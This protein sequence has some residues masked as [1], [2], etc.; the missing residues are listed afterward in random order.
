MHATPGFKAGNALATPDRK[1]AYNERV[2]TEIAPRYDRITR[3]LSFRRDA[4]WKKDLIARLPARASPRCLDV[5]CGTGDLAALLRNRYPEARITGVDLTESMLV[6]ARRRHAGARIEFVRG[7]MGHLPAADGSV[8]ILTGGYALRNAP[9]LP[10]FL[11]EARRV[12]RPDGI[13]AF[14]DFSKPDSRVRAALDHA[15][16]KLWG[17]FWGLAFHR[18]PHVYGYIAD[19]L[20]RFPARRG[21]R[22]VFQAAGLTIREGLP[23]FFGMIEIIVAEKAGGASPLTASSA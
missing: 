20:R 15:L 9:D 4:S 17:G 11:R 5:A 23:R 14:L 7:D 3:L 18:D 21:L 6:L 13:A 22:P 1:R 10:A 8:D 16:L 19:S 2:F 12:L